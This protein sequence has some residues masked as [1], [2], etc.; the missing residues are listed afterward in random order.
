MRTHVRARPRQGWHHPLREMTHY[1]PNQ[2]ALWM[3]RM[4]LH[5]KA[6]RRV[7][8]DGD[9]Q[10]EEVAQALGLQRGGRPDHP[11]KTPRLLRLLHARHQE[12]VAAPIRREG[13]L[14]RNLASIANLVGLTTVDQ[15]ILAFLVLRQEDPALRYVCDESTLLAEPTLVPDLALILG[16]KQEDVSR[17]LGR[18]GALLASG[19]VTIEKASPRRRARPFVAE[20]DSLNL[21]DGMARTL[22]REHHDPQ[23]LFTPYFASAPSPRLSVEH[24][25]YL[26]DD[27]SLLQRVL[28]GA[29]EQDQPGINILVYGLPGV[30]KTE[31][32]RAL[33]T[34]VD[35]S[36]Y[37]VSAEDHEGEALT[38]GTRMQAYLLGQRL[39]GQNRRA[40][41]LF[42]EVEDVF[43][44]RGRREGPGDR[45]AGMGKAWMNRLLEGNAR[46][47]FWVCNEIEAIDKALL[48]RFLYSLELRPPPTR[49]SSASCDPVSRGPAGHRPL[50]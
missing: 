9:P 1:D 37:E 36:L 39:L 2:V 27:V 34:A 31:L 5:A 22:F 49:H 12:L 40:V 43:Q 11:L 14:Y 38:G 30:G 26:H 35:T 46:P 7:F 6:Y 18:T 47:T 19:L 24:F 33:A 45:G 20:E 25:S 15:E 13:C 16:L 4:L 28:Q 50:D 32:V 17:A 23:T 48:R 8:D 41:L 42:D 10:A 29:I 3:L 21:L 44:E